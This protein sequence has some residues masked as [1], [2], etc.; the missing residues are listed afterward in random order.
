V[1]APNPSLMTGRGTNTYVLGRA[2]RVVVIDPGPADP[3]HLTSIDRAVGARGQAALV[4]LTHH[5]LDHSEA[6]VAVARRLG[7]PLAGIAHPDGPR[8]G[9]DLIDAEE[10]DL[11]EVTLKVLGTPGH[12]RDHACFVWKEEGAVFVGDLV[13]GEGFIVIDP[14]EGNMSDY[15]ES[16][17]RIR[18]LAAGPS[19]APAVLLP[20]HGPHIDEPRAY[21][22][23]YI[24]HR[25]QREEKVRGSIPAAFGLSAE[26]LL[27]LAYDDTPES[28]YPVAVRSLQAHLD[29]LVTEGLVEEYN[30]EYRRLV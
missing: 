19:R 29:K 27:P 26:Q 20:G 11:G 10:L 24:A 25:R 6:A 8:L 2:N 1:L 18:D 30:G 12:T 13:A 4:L 15:L 16:L 7:V 22:D 14:P 21:L 17:A 23:G 28:M 3:D 9:R 5:H